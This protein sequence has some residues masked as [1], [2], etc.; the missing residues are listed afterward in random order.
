VPS[1]WAA[2]Q[3]NETAPHVCL[4]ATFCMF[5]PCDLDLWPFDLILIGGRGIAIDYPCAE[6]EDF[7]FSSFGF[8]VQT[9]THTD[10]ITEAD[11]RYTHVTTVG[12]SNDVPQKQT[13]WQMQQIYH[14]LAE[15]YSKFNKQFKWNKCKILTQASWDDLLFNVVAIE[16]SKHRLQ[17]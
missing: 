6:F 13:N 8:I 9:D 4:D 1:R 7:S 11:Q 3:R 10:R 15:V 14:W 12:V 16:L 17:G 2:S 5:W